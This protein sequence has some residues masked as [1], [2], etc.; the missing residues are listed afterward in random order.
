VPGTPFP[1]TGTT[2]NVSQYPSPYQ[3]PPPQQQPPYYGAPPQTPAQLLAPARRA[4]ILMIVLGV[5]GVMAGL[6][7]AGVSAFVGSGQAATD[8]Q[9]REFQA[10]V[11]EIESKSGLSAQTVFLVMGAVPLAVGALMGGMGFFVRGGGLVPVVLSMT[12]TGLLVLVFAFLVIAGLIQGGASGNAQLLVGTVCVYGLP[13]AMMILLIVW[14]IQALRASTRLDLAKQQFQAQVWQ[15]QQQQQMYRQP[16]PGTGMG[17]G[18]AA[19]PGWPAGPGPAAP[20][21]QGMPSSPPPGGYH[22]Y[23]V[24]PAP[25]P[26]SAAPQ[27][28]PASSPPPADSGGTSD[29]PPPER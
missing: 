17:P 26:P 12:L 9:F 25:S 7:M 8:P 1:T 24:P 19:G 28:P 22:Q 4:G 18:P 11:Q 16:G 29:G 10:Q 2:I 5:L 20:P 23:P 27:A 15:Y 3:P 13:L 6:C 21:G 14:L